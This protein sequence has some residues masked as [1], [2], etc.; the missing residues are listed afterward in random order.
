MTKK[1][2]GEAIVDNSQAKGEM[3]T[4][5]TGKLCYSTVNVKVLG[6][7]DVQNCKRVQSLVTHGTSKRSFLP[8][9]TTKATFNS[10]CETGYVNSVLQGQHILR[11]KTGGLCDH[12]EVIWNNLF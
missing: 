11:D 7:M 8:L 2:N 5:Q 9:N 10:A 1:K 4:L 12:F 6:L 3:S